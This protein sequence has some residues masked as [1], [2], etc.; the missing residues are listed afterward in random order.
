MKLPA[1]MDSRRPLTE[2]GLAAV[3][4]DD[5]PKP[6][7][8]CLVGIGLAPF[9]ADCC[10]CSMSEFELGLRAFCC[11]KAVVRFEDRFCGEAEDRWISMGVAVAMTDEDERKRG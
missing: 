1:A 3:L 7:E 5:R 8:S 9:T 11:C 2:M 6:S 10:C 4:E